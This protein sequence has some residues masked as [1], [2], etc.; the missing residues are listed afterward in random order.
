MDEEPSSVTCYT[1]HTRKTNMIYQLRI[2]ISNLLPYEAAE[3]LHVDH[4][5][6]RFGTNHQKSQQS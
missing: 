2:W 1:N 3:Q 5:P 6:L 4:F